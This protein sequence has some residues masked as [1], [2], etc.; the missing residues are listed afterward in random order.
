MRGADLV[1]AGYYLMTM[2]LSILGTLG[3]QNE[4]ARL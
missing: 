3:D 1:K 2:V 4:G